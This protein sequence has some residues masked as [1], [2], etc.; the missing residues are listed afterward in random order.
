MGQTGALRLVAGVDTPETVIE[1]ELRSFPGP[2]RIEWLLDSRRMGSL[3]VTPEWRRYPLA[4]RG[5]G[6]G[7]S[8]LTLASSDPAIPADAI[9]HNGDKRLLALALGRWTIV[10]PAAS[11]P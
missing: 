5:L 10:G 2:R 3:H 1:V 6:A 9:L 7:T 11:T 4:L 8:T